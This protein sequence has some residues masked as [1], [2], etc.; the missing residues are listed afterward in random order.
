MVQDFCSNIENVQSMAIFPGDKVGVVMIVLGCLYFIATFTIIYFIKMQE[1][2]A[3]KGD[4]AAVQSV[5]FPVFVYVLWMNAVVNV[6]SG[7]VAWAYDFEPIDSTYKHDFGSAVA[8]AVMWG[9]QHT[10]N[11]GVSLLLMQKGLGIN[12]A[13]RALRPALLWGTFT[14]FIQL[15]IYATRREISL[16]LTLVWNMMLWGFYVTL[17][18]APN[19]RLYRRPAA[20]FYAKFW[21]VFHLIPITACILDFASLFSE[22]FC[23]FVF[24]NLFPYVILQP[25]VLYYTLLLD[26]RWWQGF[27]IVDSKN[28]STR[29]EDIR[30][31]LQGIDW[32]IRSA[33][34]LAASLDDLSMASK[35]RSAVRMLNFAYISMDTQKLLGSGSFSKVYKGSYRQRPCAIK[36]V[37]T[38]DLTQSVIKRI[39]SEALILSKIRHPNVVE[40]LGVSVLPPSVCI[41]LEL[42][43][44]GSLHDLLRG[45]GPPANFK[46]QDE[47]ESFVRA[48]ILGGDAI[49]RGSGRGLGVCWLDRLYLAR[50][51]A[52]GLQALHSYSAGLCHRDVKSFNFLLDD[53]LNVKICDLELGSVME[54]GD[55]GIALRRRRPLLDSNQSASDLEAALSTYNIQSAFAADEFLANWAAPEVIREG[56]HS[57]PSDIYSL[58]LVF[59]E[60]L[61]GNIPFHE[62]R[63]QDDIRDAVLQGVRPIVPSC[64]EEH[65]GLFGDYVTLLKR[66]WAPDPMHRPG[67]TQVVEQVEAIYRQRCFSI[68]RQTEAMEEIISSKTTSRGFSSF[69]TLPATA[70]M[71]RGLTKDQITHVWECLRKEGGNEGDSC[72]DRFE[73]SGE[74]WLLVANDG[75]FSILWASTSWEQDFGMSLDSCLGQALSEAEIVAD[76]VEAFTSRLKEVRP[77]HPRHS[78]LCLNCAVVAHP[79]EVDP[80]ELRPSKFTTSPLAPAAGAAAASTGATVPTPTTSGEGKITALFALH[81]FG[82][83]SSSSASFLSTNWSE[84][85]LIPQ[86]P[87]DAA[88]VTSSSSSSFSRLSFSM[89]SSSVARKSSSMSPSPS[90]YGGRSPMEMMPQPTSPTPPATTA[91]PSP[92]PRPQVIVEVEDEDVDRSVSVNDTEVTEG[93][94]RTSLGSDNHDKNGDDDTVPEEE[95][96]Q[97]APASYGSSVSLG[98]KAEGAERKDFVSTEVVRSSLFHGGHRPRT[99]QVVMLAILF[100][101]L[102]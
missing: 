19:K 90:F 80:N 77:L 78:V 66:C 38:L 85:I 5:I 86:A 62:T 37:F 82:I 55:E 20:L 35:G 83:T 88:P 13:K 91:G 75:C 24:G 69:F 56:L 40:I 1:G 84:D 21:V 89:R 7:F 41:L 46:E 73:E 22:G 47:E 12:A 76:G 54:E 4:D 50:G 95:H 98:D 92:P 63:R 64:F 32:D 43:P 28:K 10:V 6:Y 14:F 52:L 23:L 96:Q 11:E 70:S 59:W 44:L 67:I 30:S 34:R 58:G 101:R 16:S 79:S 48:F 102:K 29:G 2:H 31:P 45:T 53:H 26:S 81:A 49:R 68:L 8:F 65:D 61:T 9:V 27:E 94:V 87:N 25:G 15:A 18:L 71:N 72:L 51:C 3:K 99:N 74:S 39:A 97:Q 100:N 36:L 60:I 42:C 57:Q 93:E 17:W 33:Q